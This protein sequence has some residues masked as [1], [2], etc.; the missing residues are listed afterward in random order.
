MDLSCTATRF[1]CGCP[2]AAVFARCRAS[3]EQQT[4]FR[5]SLQKKHQHMLQSTAATQLRSAQQSMPSEQLTPAA[6]LRSAHSHRS[7]PGPGYQPAQPSGIMPRM[8]I[9]ATSS[10]GLTATGRCGGNVINA[11]LAIPIPGKLVLIPGPLAGPVPSV[12]TKSCVSTIH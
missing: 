10:S 7:A 8:L 12:Q 6:W 11:H 1:L 3:T 9:S 5:H 2:Q 4:D